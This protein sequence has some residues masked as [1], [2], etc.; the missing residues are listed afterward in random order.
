MSTLKQEKQQ[1]LRED[2]D[3]DKHYEWSYIRVAEG[4]TTNVVSAVLIGL[5]AIIL[6]A[7]YGIWVLIL[8]ALHTPDG[9]V[10]IAA[11]ILLGAILMLVILAIV[12]YAW[13]R[14][15]SS[16]TLAGALLGAMIGA[17]IGAAIDS[18]KLSDWIKAAT[19]KAQEQK[20][21]TK[22]GSE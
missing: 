20:N 22:T 1:K 8:S 2:A 17:A 10:G 19:A 14:G 21:A 6:G 12:I 7:V 16:A 18:G 13:V 3:T 15:I 4:V 11:L 9:L 5:G